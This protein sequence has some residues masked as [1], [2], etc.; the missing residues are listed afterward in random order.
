MVFLA[1]GAFVAEWHSGL[2]DR[3]PHL[4]PVPDSNETFPSVTVIARTLG[5]RL[6]RSKR[7][8]KLCFIFSLT[9]GDMALIVGRCYSSVVGRGVLFRGGNGNEGPRYF[10][11]RLRIHEET[12]ST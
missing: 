7:I 3:F 2:Y 8:K 6:D 11:P 10:G 12:F 9:P 4:F 1:L 5:L